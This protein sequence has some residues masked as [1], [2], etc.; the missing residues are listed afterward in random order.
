VPERLAA[1]TQFI[2]S[3]TDSRAVFAGDSDYA[4]FVA[5]LGA[6]RVSIA[7]NLGQT[8]D[9]N[10]RFEMARRLVVD[11][12]PG[13]ALAQA[14]QQGVTHLLVTPKL[15]ALHQDAFAAQ[16]GRTPLRRADLEA[17]GHLSRLYLWSGPGGD[18][19][20]IYKVGAP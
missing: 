7:D 19:V 12:Q 3:S 18:F 8:N 2:R 20:A 11:D 10:A 6:R 13:L 5:A 15:L 1:P 4:R 17:R 9:Y 14:K 16:G